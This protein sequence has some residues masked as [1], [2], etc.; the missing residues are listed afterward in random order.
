MEKATHFVTGKARLSYVSLNQPRV[1]MGGGE[2]KFSV[3]VLVPKTD[4]TTKAR[5]DAAIKAAAQLGVSKQWNGVMPPVMATPVYDGDGPRAN[6]DKFGPE[7]KGCWVFTA[8]SKADRRPRIVD[9]QVQD[10]I[11]PSEIYSGIYGRVG[12]DAYPYNRNGKRG[13]AL[14]L[15]NVQKTEEGEP[16]GSVTSAEDD[17]GSPISVGSINPI[18]GMPL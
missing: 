14:G 2:P 3:T 17:F 18:T 12:V 9:A 13:I 5:I 8:S 6:G 11:D 16:L 10:I 1:P 15:T 7:C 4:V